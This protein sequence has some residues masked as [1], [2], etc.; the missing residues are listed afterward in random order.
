MKPKVSQSKVRPNDQ[1]PPQSAPLVEGAL[2]GYGIGSP[3]WEGF[4]IEREKEADGWYSFALSPFGST[5]RKFNLG[6]N[7]QRLALGKEIADLSRR[8]PVETE[9]LVGWLEAGRP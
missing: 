6:W 3:K 7:G 9:A 5:T 2:G 8:Y 4:G 1:S